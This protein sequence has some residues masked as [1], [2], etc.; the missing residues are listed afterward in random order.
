MLFDVVF[1]RRGGRRRLRAEV[2]SDLPLRGDV[3]IAGGGIH[4]LTATL[5]CAG[6]AEPMRNLANCR[7]THLRGEHLV[8]SGIE[9]IRDGESSLREV[10]S[11]WCR[12]PTGGTPGPFDPHPPSVVKRDKS[13][14]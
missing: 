12:L 2:V 14:A 10:Q 4:G 7:L 13:Y 9:E 8:I 3:A 11:W 1:L 5:T 6:A